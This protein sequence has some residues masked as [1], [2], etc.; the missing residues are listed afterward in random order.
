MIV[1]CD[2][3]EDESDSDSDDSNDKFELRIDLAGEDF[4]DGADLDGE[5]EEDD[6]ELEHK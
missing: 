4:N 3:N 5:E 6:E 2:L 1:A